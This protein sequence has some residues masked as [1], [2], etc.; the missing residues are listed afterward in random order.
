M[1]LGDVEVWKSIVWH[2]IKIRGSTVSNHNISI[3]GTFMWLPVV[4]VVFVV[5]VF[6]S[7]FLFCCLAGPTV[8]FVNFA[9]NV[10]SIF[11]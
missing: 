3:V 9:V 10:V 11:E 4:V 5:V 6:L 8:L 2:S 7:C 1:Y